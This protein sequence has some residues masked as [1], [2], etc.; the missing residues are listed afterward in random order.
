MKNF[1]S[2]VISMV[3]VV[4]MVVSM[5]MTAFALEYLDDGYWANDAIN[6]AKTAGL[7]RGKDES[8][9]IDSE[10]YLTRA[11]MA[12]IMVRAFGA[13]VRA[14]VSNYIDL[15]QSAWYYDEFAKAVQMRIFE[16][17]GTGYMRP[18]DYIT[19]EEVFAVVARALVLSSS[20]YS[21]LSKYKDSSDI[22]TWA[23]G[24]M[25]VMTANSYVNGNA[26]G[27]VQPKNYIT[28]AEFAQVMYNI[29]KNNYI[30]GGTVK[31]QTY[32]SSVMINGEDVNLEN[33]VING[34]LIIGD[35]V[36][37]SKVILT[38]VTIN[39]RLIIRGGSTIKLD[40]TS[41]SGNVI[42]NNYNGNVH[43]ENFK[44]EIKNVIEN[45]KTTYKG[46]SGG[47]SGVI[48]P[49]SVE[50]KFGYKILYWEENANDDG[51]TLKNTVTVT[52]YDADAVTKGESKTITPVIPQYFE[53]NS[54]KSNLTATVNDD[55]VVFNVYYDRK[56]FTY[57][58]N[59]YKEQSAGAED[60]VQVDKEDYTGQFTGKYGQTVSAQIYNYGD[61]FV[62]NQAKG[63]LNG[64]I[65]GN[66]TLVLEVYYD[67]AQHPVKV[68]FYDEDN[69]LTNVTIEKGEKVLEGQFP[70][71][72]TMASG[73][74]KDGSVS[75]IYAEN[76]YTHEV[77]SGWY[78]K[79]EIRDAGGNVTGTKWEEFTT[80]TQVDAD[81]DVYR[82]SRRFIAGVNKDGQ[83]FDFT[84]WYETDTRFMDT[85]K[86]ILYSE[87]PLSA[88]ELSGYWDTIRENGKVQNILDIEDNIKNLILDIRLTE[89]IGEDNLEE[90]IEETI[91]NQFNPIV[92]ELIRQLKTEEKF[93]ITGEI[94]FVAEKL[95][96]FIETE[97]SYDAFIAPQIPERLQN[98]FD[99]CPDIEASFKGIYESAIG[100][101]LNQ[102][103]TAI[104]AVNAGGVGY[105]DT[106]ITV[107]VNLVKDI[108]IP[109]YNSFEDVIEDKVADKYYYSSNAYI[110]ELVKLLDVEILFDDSAV[111]TDEN[112]GY[113]IYSLDY[114]YNLI[115][116]AVVL[117]DD[118]LIW[119]NQE[120]D[121][122]E[123]NELTD[124]YQEL[125]LEYVNLFVDIIGNYAE[126]G[127]IPGDNKYITA[128]EKALRNKYPDLIDKTVEKFENSK[129]NKDYT[130]ED[131]QK[132]MDYVYKAF[133]NINLTTNEYFD[134]VLAIE[135]LESVDQYTK[136]SD[137]EYELAAKGI[138]ITFIRKICRYLTD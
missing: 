48:P 21:V 119:Y 57:T 9:N 4:T 131:Y 82:K 59:Y 116:K 60:Y 81:I 51:Y 17:D 6:A 45:T 90:F 32:N 129:F 46:Y 25:S 64:V 16:G 86:D 37:T 38:N 123:F 73:Y 69:E 127:S 68:T 118:T 115:Y 53:L 27:L 88:L 113:K 103:D 96:E 80:D 83:E 138:V 36:N 99:K 44:S 54:T 50:E 12:A 20:D 134:K 85:V 3:V 55:S 98:L 74:V 94:V 91:N 70:S 28:R 23:L 2:K 124:N 121:E 92:D 75:A 72:I 137:D 33:V 18:N 111:A 67:Y 76:T 89:I 47:S 52:K 41:V 100:D 42:V 11:E 78:Y 65:P 106:G 97:Y 61:D 39:G 110:Q 87:T 31:D 22:S 49:T 71:N 108:Y 10:A 7:L 79:V 95:A 14:E 62:V 29:F 120:L 15:N 63:L 114:Y 5:G 1:L 19:R 35:G 130:D 136:V 66:D 117:A 112:S 122:D 93:E 34:D 58:V 128:L 40:K 135:S 125:V 84:A 107:V 77:F 24:Y 126:D 26:E 133:Q 30:N 132:A 13:S 43:F 104:I 56:E 101:L 105:V 8:G 109:V 102:F